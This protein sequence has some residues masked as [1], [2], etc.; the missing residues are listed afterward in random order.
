[1]SYLDVTH[2]AVNVPDLREAESYYVGLFSL[3]V[4]WRDSGGAASLF[5]S[6]DEIAAAGAE[7]EVVMLWRDAFKLALARAE[8]PVPGLGALSHIGLQVTPEQLAAVRAGAAAYGM[9]VLQVRE[10]ELF[11]F[12][13]RY[14]VQWEL[15]TRSFQDPREIGRQ[16]EARQR[17]RE[18]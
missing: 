11:S 3:E 16:V 13:D 18:G 15:D 4:A 6:W 14:G 5:A 17:R 9:Q 10:D 2:I 8:T 7:P 1:V 12:L